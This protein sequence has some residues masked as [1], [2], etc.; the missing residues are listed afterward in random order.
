MKSIWSRKGQVCNGILRIETGLNDSGQYEVKFT[1]LSRYVG[2]LVS[3]EEDMTKKSARSLRPEIRSQW[4]H[5][6]YKFITRLVEKVLEVERDM[7]ENHDI[8][9]KESPSAK[10]FR[11][12]SAPRIG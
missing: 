4:F 1:Q 6:N 7:Q 2:K 5:F 9:A 11:Y 8:R 10:R 3:E 12:L